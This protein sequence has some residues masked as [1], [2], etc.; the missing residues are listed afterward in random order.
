MVY[1]GVQV[2]P[3]KTLFITPPPPAPALGANLS[4]TNNGTVSGFVHNLNFFIPGGFFFFF[5]T[6]PFSLFSVNV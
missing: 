5:F 1:K 3:Y 6:L 4:I 2:S